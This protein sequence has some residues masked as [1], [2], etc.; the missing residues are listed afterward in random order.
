LDNQSVRYFRCPY[1]GKLDGGHKKTVAKTVGW[2]RIQ[3]IYNNV[4]ILKCR[5]CAKVCRIQMVGSVLEW[6]DMSVAERAVEKMKFRK[7]YSKTKSNGG[8]K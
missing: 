7:N 6:A 1:C 3:Q 2:F 4:L 5:R 8:K